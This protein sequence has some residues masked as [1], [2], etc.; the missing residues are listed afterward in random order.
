MFIEKEQML[1]N[2]YIDLNRKYLDYI[3]E[4]IENIRLS[5]QEVSEKCD[6]MAWVGD[7]YTWH[8]LR[9]QICCHDI[10]KFSH[11]E[12]IGYR[13]KFYEHKYEVQEDP[14]TDMLFD[15]AWE[16]HKKYNHHHW[17]MI[18]E[19]INIEVTPGLVENNIVHMIV[20]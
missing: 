16:H 9:Q 12:F 5:F 18:E 15:R 6:G 3:E 10:S 19:G 7:D 11:E 20:D 8:T 17:E 2:E 13:R 14:V 1:A 4:H